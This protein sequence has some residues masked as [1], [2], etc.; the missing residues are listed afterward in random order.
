MGT[1]VAS[2]FGG[3]LNISLSQN[4]GLVGMIWIMSR[5]VVTI[6]SIIMII[7]GLFPKIGAVISSMPLPVLGGGVI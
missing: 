3:L 2:V 5:H 1:A 6:A 7:C 4:N